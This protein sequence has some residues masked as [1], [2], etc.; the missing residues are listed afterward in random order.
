MEWISW[1]TGAA[2]GQAGGGAPPG[3]EERVGESHLQRH[4]T[5][6]WGAL[7]TFVVV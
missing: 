2:Q 4:L 3:G 1:K 5:P 7:C 6:L